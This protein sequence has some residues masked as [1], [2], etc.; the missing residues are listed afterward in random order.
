MGAT[1]ILDQTPDSTQNAERVWRSVPRENSYMLFPGNLLH[2]VLPCTRKSYPEDDETIDRL[3]FMVG[4]WTRRVPDGM[5]TR[6][7]YGPCGPLP[8]A[9][10]EHTWVRSIQEGYGEAT[11]RDIT[12]KSSSE[13]LPAP[14]AVP[15]V[16]PAWEE[17][18]CCKCD[19]RATSVHDSPPLQIPKALDHRFFVHGAPRCF[20]D[21]LFQKD[22]FDEEEEEEDGEED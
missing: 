10:D 9:T 5:T 6:K 3:T 22:E 14:E 12:P 11:T 19:K 7:L 18:P 2:G 15:Q 13:K 8:P 20:R 21:S 16:S 17:I 4:F 1:I